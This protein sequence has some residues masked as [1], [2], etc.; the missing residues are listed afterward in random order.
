MFIKSEH[1]LTGKGR[2][3]YIIIFSIFIGVLLI[4][5]PLMLRGVYIM[6]ITHLYG[7]TGGGDIS[8]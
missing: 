4:F 5:I 7:Y 2:P 8:F 1:K 3:V 6:P